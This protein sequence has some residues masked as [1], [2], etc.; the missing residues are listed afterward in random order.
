MA[1]IAIQRLLPLLESLFLART[2]KNIKERHKPIEKET[3]NL[4]GGQAGV[5]LT[6]PANLGR[7]WWPS[8]RKKPEDN[9]TGC[10]HLLTHARTSVLHFYF[11]FLGGEGI[12]F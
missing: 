10:I 9:A 11:I 4:A 8:R 6:R 1:K 7:R 3:V 12:F 2:K 5:Q